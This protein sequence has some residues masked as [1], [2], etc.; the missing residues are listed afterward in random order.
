MKEGAFLQLLYNTLK[1]LGIDTKEVKA[2]GRKLTADSTLLGE[3]NPRVGETQKDQYER[4]KPRLKGFT[5][6]AI[7]LT[8][9]I[10]Q[11]AWL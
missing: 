3:R 8:K 6:S 7:C 4:W 10:K 5:V 11:L 2:K 9:Y 1:I